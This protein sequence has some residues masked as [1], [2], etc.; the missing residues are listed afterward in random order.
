MPARWS[1]LSIAPMRCL[2]KEPIT[3]W[4]R[5]GPVI[6]GCIAPG[7]ITMRNSTLDDSLVDLAAIR[8]RQSVYPGDN[9]SPVRHSSRGHPKRRTENFGRVPPDAVK[10]DATVHPDLNNASSLGGSWQG[11]MGWNALLSGPAGQSPHR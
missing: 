6:A 11:Q 4:W 1:T 5:F 10:I 2:M 9:L 7:E 8:N 3:T